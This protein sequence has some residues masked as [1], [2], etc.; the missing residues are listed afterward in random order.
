MKLNY[1]VLKIDLLL[2]SQKEKNI[3]SFHYSCI[4]ITFHHQHYLL[5]QTTLDHI[6]LL[7]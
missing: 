7:F 4:F 5:D 6:I 1:S 3:L 2:I